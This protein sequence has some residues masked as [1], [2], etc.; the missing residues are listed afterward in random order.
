MIILHLETKPKQSKHGFVNI[1]SFEVRYIDEQLPEDCR[2]STGRLREDCW[3]RLHYYMTKHHQKQ[4]RVFNFNTK[5]LETSAFG[6]GR[7]LNERGWFAGTRAQ[8]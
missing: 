6:F 1:V 7:R 5:D 8:R 3:K 4:R 2:K